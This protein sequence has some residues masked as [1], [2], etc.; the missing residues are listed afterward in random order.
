MQATEGNHVSLFVLLIN[1]ILELFVYNSV[2]I[3]FL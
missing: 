3:N 2:K 1:I